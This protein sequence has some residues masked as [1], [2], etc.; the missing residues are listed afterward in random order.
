[1]GE[2][3]LQANSRYKK[4]RHIR[5]IV[6]AAFSCVGYEFV[7]RILLAQKVSLKYNLARNGIVFIDSAVDVD[8]R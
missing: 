8:R 1:M 3:K 6:L 2:S 7:G 4:Q 5:E